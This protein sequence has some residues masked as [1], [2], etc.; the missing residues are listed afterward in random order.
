M[1]NTD[2]PSDLKEKLGNA[3][4]GSFASCLYEQEYRA[5]TS[6]IVEFLTALN[7]TA[8]EVSEVLRRAD[9]R[10]ADTDRCIDEIIEAFND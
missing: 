10:G 1:I 4:A 2:Y 5:V 7:L 6:A 3:V 8:E 9:G